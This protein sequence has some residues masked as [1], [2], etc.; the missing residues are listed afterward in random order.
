MAKAKEGKGSWIVTI[1]ATVT[2]K[3]VC[4]N[5]TEAQARNDPFEFAVDENEVEQDDWEIVRVE[6]NE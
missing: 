4:E 5:C 2:K 1:H 3:V 6:P